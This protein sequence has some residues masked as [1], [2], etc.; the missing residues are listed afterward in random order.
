MVPP[1]G[2]EGHCRIVP[3]LYK[4]RLGG[5]VIYALKL[6]CESVLFQMVSFAST[7]LS[8]DPVS[9]GVKRAGTCYEL[10]LKNNDSTRDDQQSADHI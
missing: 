1:L 8:Y 7:L 10:R 5:V 6:T 3:P 2:R 9:W 4:G